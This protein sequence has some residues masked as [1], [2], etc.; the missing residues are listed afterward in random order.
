MGV[1]RPPFPR[2]DGHRAPIQAIGTI[3][4]RRRAALALF[5]IAV[6][7]NLAVVIWLACRRGNAA[8]VGMLL[9][10]Q[11]AGCASLHPASRDGVAP[12]EAAGPP[13]PLPRS[14]IEAAPPALARSGPGPSPSAAILP[15]AAVIPLDLGTAL[16]LAEAVNPEIA[17]SR[18]AIR[19][20]LALRQGARALLLPSLNAGGNYHGHTGPV[21][22]STGQINSLYPE[23]SLYLGGG[24]E[25]AAAGTIAIPA[26]W[27][28]A[29]LAD[30][31]YDPPAA[32]RRVEEARSVAQAS[33][34]EILLGVVTSYLELVEA[35]AVLG[36]YRRS[37]SEAQEVR[38]AIDAN[39]AGGR[40]SGADADRAASD[41][42]SRRAEVLRAEEAAAIASARLARRLRLDPSARIWP[43]AGPLEPSLLIDP[44]A[45]TRDLID[46]AS[47]SRPELA[48]GDA[49]IAL[50][51]T[52]L[53]QERARPLLPTVSVGFSGG[54]YGGGSNQS[55]PLV[56][57]FAGRTDFDVLA[58]WSVQDLGFGNRAL[59]RRRSAEHD[60]AISRRS[61]ALDRVRTEVAEARAEAIASRR[62]IEIARRESESAE[63]GFQAD[64]DR[65]RLGGGLPIEALQSLRR[66]EQARRSLIRSVVGSD[67][68]QFALLVALGFAPLDR[69]PAPGAGRPSPEVASGRPAFSTF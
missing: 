55:P 17:L 53:A 41:V 27:I 46:L 30:A 48:A 21:Q 18:E 24:A 8:A 25:T 52:R 54:A 39:L 5:A 67:R 16:R 61:L 2:M 1:R 28:L 36:T 6:V 10:A 23:Q 42:G 31:L 13:R 51:R 69:L 35:E 4:L 19:G 40:G 29:P 56:G 47:R 45:D 12:I 9:A 62:G 14:P 43:P 3:G 15:P 68:A 50:A 11:A 20:T 37:E 57:R 60:Q 65:L 66:L 7:A 34:H 63:A 26:V 33:S 58:F 44:D 59:R 64:L 49:A 32:D 38:K 22:K